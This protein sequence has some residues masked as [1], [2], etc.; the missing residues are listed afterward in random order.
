[1]NLFRATAFFLLFT[2]SA[3]ASDTTA[4][5]QKRFA[6]GISFS[7]DYCFR[8]LVL[9]YPTENAASAFRYREATEI[10]MLGYSC[11][12]G[13]SYSW[14][15]DLQASAGLGFSQKG[16]QT[17]DL[18][19]IDTDG[20]VIGLGKYRNN[21]DYIQ[22][23][24]K[25]CWTKGK[26]KLKFIAEAGITP[27]YLLYERSNLKID[28]FDGRSD[29]VRSDVNY[30][31]RTFGWFGEIAAGAELKTGSAS[32]IRIEPYYSYAFAP[33]IST[34]MTEYLRNSGLKLSCHFRL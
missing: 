22:L 12:I 30:I 3:F 17:R 13:L 2:A 24:V 9:N 33:T 18:L 32:V 20:N 27:S 5:T 26:K 29:V 10:P 11:S 16:F 1:M 4:V 25:I 23:P 8:R 34:F 31:N 7:P 6:I 15:Y 21:F 28:Y 19:I 14:K